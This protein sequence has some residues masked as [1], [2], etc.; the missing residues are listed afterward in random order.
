MRRPWQ[1]ILSRTAPECAAKRNVSGYP[2]YRPFPVT[3]LSAA[4]HTVGQSV[5]QRGVTLIASVASVFPAWRASSRPSGSQCIHPSDSVRVFVPAIP[6]PA[7]ESSG[8]A[9]LQ[10]AGGLLPARIFVPKGAALRKNRSRSIARRA[11]P[12]P[13][14]EQGLCVQ[15]R[16]QLATRRVARRDPVPPDP[17]TTSLG[18]AASQK[19]S[20]GQGQIGQCRIGGRAMRSAIGSAR[21]Q[22][23]GLFPR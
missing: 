20:T 23:A 7:N 4:T 22:T 9:P 15:G 10:V 12:C 17:S 5:S 1:V 16:R 18:R 19:D 13:A 14:D 21:N 8:H 2:Q 11:S 3:V 6:M